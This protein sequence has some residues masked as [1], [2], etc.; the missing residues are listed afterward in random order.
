MKYYLYWSLKITT[1]WL[2]VILSACNK[3]RYPK[4]D[5]N[6]RSLIN[7]AKSQILPIQKGRLEYYRFGEGPPLVLLPGY[8][9]DISSWPTSFLLTLSKQHE[10]ILL[11]YRGVG[12]SKVSA[13]HYQSKD[14]A[15]DVYQLIKGLRIEDPDVV[16]ISMGGMIAQ[17]LAVLHQTALGKLILI[18]TAI[19]GHK[20]IHPRP[21][22]ER[23]M[24][25]MPTSNIKKL[26]FAVRLFFPFPTRFPMLIAL[27]TNRYVPHDY[28]PINSEAILKDQKKLILAWSHDDAI[29]H[30]IA[31]LNMPVLIL[32]GQGDG[33][34]PPINSL[35]LKKHYF[36]LNPLVLA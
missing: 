15:E 20:S 17:H 12:R 24:L 8:L 36:K 14:L 23:Q 4:P 19:S 29:A 7:N 30:S 34:I 33:V 25:N 27:V 6:S 13:S 10:V 31:H 35:I 28:Q 11:N 2:I 9:T 21:A 1:I 3:Y 26:I 18:N 22:I 5:I 16:G 32:N